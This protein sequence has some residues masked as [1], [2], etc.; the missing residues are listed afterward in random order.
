MKK[1]PHTNKSTYTS[2]KALFLTT[3]F[4]KV[5]L[6]WQLWPIQKEQNNRT[7]H[8]LLQTRG[9][10]GA[11]SD[12]VQTAMIVILKWASYFSTNGR[13]KKFLM[14]GAGPPIRL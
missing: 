3:P 7:L 10:M 13:H 5:D 12:Q 9:Y 8:L 6:T 14:M 2:R 11:S 4:E 1:T